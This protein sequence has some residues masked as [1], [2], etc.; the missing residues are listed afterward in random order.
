MVFAP[1]HPEAEIER[2]KGVVLQEMGEA[3]DQPDPVMIIC[4]EW[5]DDLPCPVAM[6]YADGWREVI[7]DDAGSELRFHQHV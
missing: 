6:Q 2:E 4:S 7:I 5:L 1:D 3:L